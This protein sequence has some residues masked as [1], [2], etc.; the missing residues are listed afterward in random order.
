MKM[1]KADKAR[2]LKAQLSQRTFAAPESSPYKH[3]GK[4]LHVHTHARQERPSSTSF[5]CPMQ[6]IPSAT[7][8]RTFHKRWSLVP[9]T[10]QLPFQ[11]NDLLLQRW[12]GGLQILAYSVA[13]IKQVHLFLQGL[14]KFFSL[15]Y[16]LCHDDVLLLLDHIRIEL[17]PLCLKLNTCN[18]QSTTPLRE[19]RRI[20]A[21]WLKKDLIGNCSRK[22][23]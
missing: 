5:L 4:M 12:V 16:Y 11:L 1:S 17:L 20:K 8:A 18:E 13:C 2:K 23:Y 19:W 7:L 10:R 6:Q 15:S 3:K 14:L 22:F 9:Q 21:Q